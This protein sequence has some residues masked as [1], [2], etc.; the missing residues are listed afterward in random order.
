MI[1]FIIPTYDNLEGLKTLVGQVLK[2]TDNVSVYVVE[3]GLKIETR[4]WL[5][6]FNHDHMQGRLYWALH[7]ENMGV[8][9]SWNDGIAMAMHDGC[10]HFVLSNDDIEL[11]DSWW[12]PFREAFE[13]GAHLV[14]LDQPCPVP[15]VTGWF[16]ALDRKT[17]E[18]V[19]L[20][21]EQFTKFTSE[22]QDYA[23]RFKRSGLAYAKVWA[24]IVHHG[25]VTMKKVRKE[26]PEF[27]KDVWNENWR[28]LRAKYPDLRMPD[29]SL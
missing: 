9:K 1:A 11:C 6:S 18:T 10:T 22:D 2:L 3:D 8:A 19:G 29:Q 23:I 21:D 16:F 14:S 24:P 26:N 28:K 20:F 27:Y 15:I 5:T 25:S 4:K 7:P 17:I 12:N 13:D